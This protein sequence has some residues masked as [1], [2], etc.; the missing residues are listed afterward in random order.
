MAIRD[1]RVLAVV[2]ARGGSKGIPGKNLRRVGDRSLVAHAA[3]IACKLACVDAAI[4]STDDPEIAAEGERHGLEVPFLRPAALA[5]DFATSVDVWRHAWLEAERGH[6]CRFDISILLEPTS[7]LRRLEDVE[8][9]I[10]ALLASGADCCFTVSETPAHFSP[11]KT[12]WIRPDQRI[13]FY[14]PVAESETIRQRIPAYVHRNGI[15]Y[16]VRRG[17][18]IEGGKIIEPGSL[19]VLIERPVVNIDD[20]FELD[21]ANWLYQRQLSEGL[22]SHA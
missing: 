10:E 1:L 6:G 22:A 14:L 13:E 5:G 8:R 4:L 3:G 7:P 12:L 11:Q 2:P 16:V 20:P 21:L 15:C 19:P 18:L 9:A 17:H